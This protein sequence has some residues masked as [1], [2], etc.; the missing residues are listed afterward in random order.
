MNLV[1]FHQVKC[2]F[3]ASLKTDF[4]ENSKMELFKYNALNDQIS[5]PSGKQSTIVLSATLNSH[6]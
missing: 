3:L 1:I 2:I 6:L 5:E 4:C